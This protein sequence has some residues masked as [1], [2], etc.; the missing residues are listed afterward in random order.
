MTLDIRKIID[1]GLIKK[2]FEIGVG[3][4]NI[5]KSSFFINYPHI[6]CSLFEPNPVLFNKLRECFEKYSN[7]HLYNCA[8]GG[9]ESNAMLNMLG[10]CS[11]IEGTLSPSICNKTQSEESLQKYKIDIKPLNQYDK[12]DIDILLL[13]CEGYEFEVIKTLV[14]KPKIISIELSCADYRTPNYEKI[15][16]WMYENDYGMIDRANDKD[17]I[18][19]SDSVFIQLHSNPFGFIQKVIK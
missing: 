19:M 3:P 7:F 1:S 9:Q 15:L 17:W 10:E 14:S 18:L 16:A 8:I 13:D 4:P 12:G 5:C 6:Q 11:W 2:I